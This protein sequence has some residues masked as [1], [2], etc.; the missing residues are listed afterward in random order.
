MNSAVVTDN[1]LEVAGVVKRFGGVIAL[2]GVSLAIPRGQVTALVG[3]NGAGKST[4]VR[5]LSG[6]HPPDEGRIFVGGELAVFGSP[7][8]ARAHGIETVFQELALADNLDVSANIFLGRELRHGFR[9]LYRLKK[10]EMAR[11]SEEL[12]RRYAINAPSTSAKVRRLSGGQRQGVAI[13]RAVGTGHT[14]AVLMDEPTAALGVQET[15]KVLDI[16]RKLAESGLAVLLISHNMQQVIDIA[17]HVYVLRGGRM[18]ADMPTSGT[19]T[20]E[21]VHYI[22]TGVAGS[23]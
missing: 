17:D 16:I 19:S 7:L 1:A 9:G 2:D 10:K 18:A 21:L 15:A 3:D 14:Q 6:V 20:Q 11:R 8:G 23:G 22:T 12:L 5:C 4:L 13:A